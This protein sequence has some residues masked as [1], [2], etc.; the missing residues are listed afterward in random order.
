M[1]KST[2]RMSR[3]LFAAIFRFYS[4]L[5]KNA[6]HVQEARAQRYAGYPALPE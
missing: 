5:T 6:I 3:E 2:A 4:P 1:E